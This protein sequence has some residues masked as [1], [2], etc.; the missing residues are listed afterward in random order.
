MG[1][2]WF[3]VLLCVLGVPAVQAE[4]AL[5][6]EIRLVSEVW[7]GHSNAD[8]TGLGWDLMRQVFEP[9]GVKVHLRSAPYVRSIGLVQRDEADAW[10]G[11]YRDE[12]EGVLYPRWHYSVD[13][14]QA[15][16]LAAKPVPTLET[17]GRYRL[18]W[19]RGY[20]YQ[21]Y[22]PNLTHYQEIQRRSGIPSMLALGHADFYIDADTEVSEVLAETEDRTA[23]RATELTKLPL[24]LGFADT[25]RGQALAAL[26]D[27]RMAKL[28][29]AG[30]LRKYFQRWKQPY[31][32]DKNSEKPDA[33]P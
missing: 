27:E 32:F 33:T 24:Y 31:P 20:E 23:Y 28:V 17:L 13:R 9:A 4:P 18:V 7:D 30:S 14:I 26:F 25:P 12:V 11:S 6:S 19:I 5:P 16:G 8:G 21:R 2:W 22:L 29:K 15:L 3:G 1:S 10:L